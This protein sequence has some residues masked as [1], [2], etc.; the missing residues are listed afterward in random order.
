MSVMDESTLK[1][2]NQK[3][4]ETSKPKQTTF[5]WDSIV[6]SVAFSILGLSISSIIAEFFSNEYSVAC[7]SEFENRAQY[8]YI[9]SY[10]HKDLPKTEYFPLIVLLQ[11]ALLPAPHY[12]WKVLFSAEIE[13]FLSHAARVEILREG[14]TEKYPRQNYKI[15][16]YLQRE[17]DSRKILIIYIFMLGFQVLLVIVMLTA[18]AVVFGDIRSRDIT[19][20]CGDDNHLFGNVTCAYPRKLFINVLI[21]IDYALLV[22][23]CI[24]LIIGLCWCLFWRNS[25]KDNKNIAEFCHDSCIDP[26]YYYKLPKTCKI[27][28][29]VGCLQKNDFSFLLASLN[30]GLKRV[31]NTILI[32]DIISQTSSEYLQT[33]N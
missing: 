15:V 21:G 2:L 9:N 22:I 32:E 28:K 18:N 8:T 17:F 7:F 19:F 11:A 4:E 5:F 23:A 3:L 29:L 26:Q 13:S 25:I 10:C 12:F 30:S 20:Q 6:F 27:S 16:N 33:G 1:L 24:M 14:N 31:F